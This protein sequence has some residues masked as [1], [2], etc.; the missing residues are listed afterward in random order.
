MAKVGEQGRGDGRQR[1]QWIPTLT[2]PL[3]R[4]QLGSA[5]LSGKILPV[6][7]LDSTFEILI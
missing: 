2:S 4:T 6:S 5:W 3:Q 7:P 1:L